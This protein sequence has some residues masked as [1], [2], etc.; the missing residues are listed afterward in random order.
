MGKRAILRYP[1]STVIT[2][3]SERSW[4]VTQYQWHPLPSELILPLKKLSCCLKSLKFLALN[5]SY[6]SFTTF[7][8]EPASP[9]SFRCAPKFTYRSKLAGGTNDSC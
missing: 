3:G 7:L 6:L 4:Q 5:R 8:S 9:S 2:E 1:D